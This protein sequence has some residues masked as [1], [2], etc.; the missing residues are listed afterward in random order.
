MAKE[1]MAK[2]GI[3][4]I[5]RNFH[6]DGKETASTIQ[7]AIQPLLNA[8]DI[9]VQLVL[10]K[11]LLFDISNNSTLIIH[12]P[13]GRDLA[14]FDGI[15]MTNWFS[16][17]SIR[18]DMAFTIALYLKRN[19]V[20]LLNSEALHS[21]SSSKLS[22]M[23]IAAQNNISIP[24]TLF[25]LSLDHLN[26]YLNDK[27]I[28]GP[29]IFKNAQA[30]RGN[31]N[32]LLES[33]NDILNYKNDHTEKK[34]FIVQNLI[35][36]DGS[37]YRFFV[38]GGKPKL[39][40]KRIGDDSSHL[41]NTSAGASTEMAKVSEFQNNVLED[42]C[43][44]SQLLHREVTGIDIIFDKVGQQSYFLEANPIPQIATGSNVEAKLEVLADAIKDMLTK[45]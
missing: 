42:V 8:R 10:F 45:E 39:V 25:S 34:P 16:H 26:K 22:Q 1:E 41:N 43:K 7:A 17:A 9:S 13:S 29:I 14:S 3:A 32:Y 27:N 38:A 23:M 24:R 18:K 6:P 2:A 5:G 12:V 33:A 36:S 44:I 20:A 28:K 11:D 31:D 19:G 40:I 15:F 4:I 35:Q 37:D 30:S 21:R